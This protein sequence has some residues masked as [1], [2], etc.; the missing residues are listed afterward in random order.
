[1]LT[2]NIIFKNFKLNKNNKNNKK[3][4]NELKL[5]LKEENA[6]IQSLGPTYKNNYNKK[7]ISKLKNFSLIR[8]IGMGGAILGTKS[9]YHFL[10]HKIKKKFYFY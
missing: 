6:I 8:I 4:R 2:K 7:T 5:L 10:K 3:I 9:I 1:M